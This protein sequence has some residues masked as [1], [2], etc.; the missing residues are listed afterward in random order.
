[1]ARLLVKNIHHKR[2][3]MLQWDWT[4]CSKYRHHFW[5]LLFIFLR[6]RKYKLWPWVWFSALLRREVWGKQL[7]WPLHSGTRNWLSFERKQKI[8]L[9]KLV[10]CGL[11]IVVLYT[12]VSHGGTFYLFEPRPK[13]SWLWGFI[14]I[15]LEPRDLHVDRRE[16]TCKMQSF[17]SMPPDDVSFANFSHVCLTLVNT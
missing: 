9:H 5:E 3:H 2:R 12:K 6:S 15:C 8:D 16:L 11:K 17:T 7:D 1:M 10:W 14:F 13:F 4:M